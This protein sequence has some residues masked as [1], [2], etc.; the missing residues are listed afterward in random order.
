MCN[1]RQDGC[2]LGTSIFYSWQTVLLFS[3][4]LTWWIVLLYDYVQ[5]K[6]ETYIWVVC[7]KLV[8]RFLK[9]IPINFNKYLPE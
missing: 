2:K 9:I 6:E 5:N 4:K 1:K 8:T 7:T 3:N